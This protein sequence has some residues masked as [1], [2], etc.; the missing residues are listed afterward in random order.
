MIQDKIFELSEAD[1][2]FLRNKEA[3]V[4]AQRD[5]DLPVN[6]I[7]KISNKDEIKSVIELGSSNGYRLNFLKKTLPHCNNF[8]GMDPSKM[9]VE[10]GKSNYGLKMYLSTLDAFK[11]DEKFDLAIV[12][13]V[14]HW[15]DREN[16]FAAIANTDKLINDG[17]YLIIGDFLPDSP[18]KRKYHH[19]QDQLVYTYKID[20]AKIF[21]SFNTY[22]EIH[23]ITYNCND[24]QLGNINFSESENRGFCSVLKKDLYGYYYTY[25]N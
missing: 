8:V 9:A 3:I 17:G 14:Y 15:I 16:I 12:N 21:E 20:Y 25:D 24:H 7:E 23:R 18:Q 13:F 22:K 19:L 5:D 1:N 4:N 6:L 10:Y 2:W 11:S